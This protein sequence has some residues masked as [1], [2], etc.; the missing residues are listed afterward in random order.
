MTTFC[1]WRLFRWLAACA[2]AGGLAAQD[3]RAAE[4]VVIGSIGD[5]GVAA[6]GDGRR[7]IE[8]AVADVVKRWNVVFIF[9]TGDNNYPSGASSTMDLNIGQFFHEYIHPYLGAHGSGAITN[10]FFPCLGNHDWVDNGQPQSDYFALPGNERYYSHHQGP[11]E[12]F[13]INSNAD[14]DGTSSTSVQGRWLQAALAASTARWKLVSVHHPP[15]S[16]DVGGAGNPGLR[17]PFAAWGAS[18]VFAGHDHVYARIHTNGIVYFLNGLGGDGIHAFAG[19]SAAAVRD[20]SDYGAMRLEATD[21]NIVFH[22]ISRSNVVVD[23]HVLGAPIWSPFILAPPLD[24]TVLAG[25]NVTF[26]VLATGA[27][28][29][30]YQWESNSVNIPDATNRVLTINETQPVHHGDYAVIVSCGGD[31]RRSAVARLTVVCHPLIL[32][33]PAPQTVNGGG[34]ASFR[35]TAE[36]V[37]PL[38][39]QWLLNGILIPGATATN[40]VLANVSLQHAGDY[41][42][43]VTDGN[44]S[45]TSNPAR[46]TVLVRPT[47]TLPPASQTAVVGETV[48]FSTAAVGTLPMGYSWRRNGRIVTN[49]LISQFTC[50]WAISNVQLTD[51]GNYQMGVT[52]A[53]GIATGGLTP[54]AVLTV[55]E[56][57]DGDGMPDPWESAHGLDPAF[58]GDAVLDSDGDG[59]SNADE[60]LAGTDP[61]SRGNH[62]RIESIRL[63]PADGAKLEFTAV[64]NKT[65]AVEFR[66]EIQSGTWNLLEPIPAVNT[67]RV[68]EVFDPS[69]PAPGLRRFYRL[70]TPRVP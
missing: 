46:L 10:R 58:A 30:R 48:V 11:V 8:R 59:A 17:W 63:L 52:N 38:S 62:L 6:Y 19:A 1:F 40:L 44:G 33:Q 69:T 2:I 35:V 39:C 4:S 64:S 9:T 20:N 49:I 56:D 15:Y 14:P 55:L 45:I 43:R 18:A 51:N 61:N 23:T 42:A 36:G 70:V 53:A 37:G 41:A 54:I 66:N 13:I 7:E 26:D 24:Q 5:F 21:T 22:F 32:Q 68:V 34:T 28:S 47:V 50:F 25:R 3:A 57:T 16:A 27:A 65:Y 12:I 60:Y 31:S 67:N 29:L